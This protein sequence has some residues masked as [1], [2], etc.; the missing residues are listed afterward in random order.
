MAKRTK[1]TG[2]HGKPSS[3]EGF[4]RDAMAKHKERIE[5][6]EKPVT[7]EGFEV[8]FAPPQPMP[9]GAQM[10][11]LITGIAKCFTPDAQR[12][13]EVYE[14]RSHGDYR[15]AD[16]EGLPELK[17]EAEFVMPEYIH[18]Y[19]PELYAVARLLSNLSYRLAMTD[20]P[21]LAWLHERAQEEVENALREDVLIEAV[22]LLAKALVRAQRHLRSLGLL[23]EIFQVLD[24]TEEDELNNPSSFET[25]SLQLEGVYE[26]DD[27]M[28]RAVFTKS[29][30]G[31]A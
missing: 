8:I 19:Y 17:Q 13:R 9:T 22:A 15:V 5:A 4:V 6:Q 28:V 26:E 14:R 3:Y 30:I 10:D 1:R 11:V 20:D 29:Q 31:S 25:E 21:N 27:S 18:V 12:L 2:T 7:Y 24:E 23:Q 16:I